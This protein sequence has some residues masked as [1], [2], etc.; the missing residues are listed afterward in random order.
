MSTIGRVVV[1][2][3]IVEGETPDFETYGMAT[4]IGCR[5]WVWLGDVSYRLVVDHDAQPLCLHCAVTANIQ[6]EQYAGTV[7]DTPRRQP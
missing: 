1:L 7:E 2:P 3:R 5:G 6:P 4:C